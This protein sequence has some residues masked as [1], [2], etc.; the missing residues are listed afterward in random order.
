MADQDQRAPRSDAELIAAIRAG[1]PRAADELARRHYPHI[2]AALVRQ[3]G[4]PEA[5]RDLAQDTFLDAFR[6]L[7]ALRTP[8]AF[9]AWLRRIS[10]NHARLLIR[11]RIA[12]P[13][14]VPLDAA[15]ELVSPEPT[16]EQ[17]L[18][19][20]VLAALSRE[21][22]AVLIM[23]GMLNMAGADI[24]ASLGLSRAAAYARV[25]RARAR[26]LVRYAEEQVEE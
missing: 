1:S 16:V 7:G 15:P 11:R 26:F 14:D 25:E 2:F 10:Q 19:R 8:R 23:D 20:R 12:T 4:D 9:P 17:R 21:D 22:R 6:A 18:V 3:I 24:A 5:A 13:L